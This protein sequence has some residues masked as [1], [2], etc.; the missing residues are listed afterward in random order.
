SAHPDAKAVTMVFSTAEI[1]ASQA[2]TQ[3]FGAGKTYPA[4]PLLTTYYANLPVIDMIRKGQ[5]DAAAENPLEWTGWG[6]IDQL[7]EDFTRKTPSSTDERPDY[8]PGLDFWRPT[9]VT[10]DNLPPE[11]QLL[12]PTVDFAGFF[13]AKWAAEF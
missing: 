9:V 11:G 2:L 3:R 7:A 13:T 6:A 12:A 8:G 10:K 4:R 1:G 5:L